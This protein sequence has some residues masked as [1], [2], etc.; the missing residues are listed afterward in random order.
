MENIPV[1]IESIA[2]KL[3]EKYYTNDMPPYSDIPDIP[4]HW[5]RLWGIE[6]RYLMN[7]EAGETVGS[8]GLKASEDAITLAGKT[9][10]D[11]DL[12]LA[13][14]CCVSGWAEDKNRIYPGLSHELKK[15]L[16]C[17]SSCVTIEVNQA[18]IS[19]MVSLQIASEYIKAGVYKNILICVSESF[20]SQFDFAD[21]S[22]TLYADG[23]A[24]VIVSPGSNGEGLLSSAYVSDS[25]YCDLATIQWRYPNKSTEQRKPE[26]L[27][28]YFTMEENALRK[29]Q[30]IVPV[31]VPLMVRKVLDDLQLTVDE[32]D[33]FIFHQ[34]SKLLI[35]LWAD[36]IGVSKDKF[37]ITVDKFSCLASVSTPL[38]LYEALK[39][40]KIHNK[41]VFAGAG[42][43]W[44]FGAQIWNINKIKFI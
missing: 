30:T 23:A 39:Q 20:S 25:K 13:T 4:A 37:M 34:P 43:G 7:R 26:D 10:N 12:I 19:F 33:F 35:N 15:K 28:S 18:C 9:A 8:L 41:I 11:I 40:D 5:W 14:T 42:T 3:P 38:T 21:A 27:R 17:K 24:A 31:K 22:S 32:I 16:G 29:M 2:V 36:A 6:G 1:Q 44:G